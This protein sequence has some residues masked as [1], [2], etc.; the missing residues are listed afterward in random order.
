[1]KTLTKDNFSEALTGNSLVFFHRLKGCGNCDK[2]LPIVEDYKKE[3]V[4]VFDVDCDAEKE[5]VSKYAPNGNWNLPLFVYFEEGKPV[6]VKTGVINIDD[7]TKTLQNVSIMELTE[8]KLEL[9]VQLANKKRET[10]MI[11]KSIASIMEEIDRRYSNTQKAQ[12][13]KTLDLSG[14]PEDPEAPCDGCQ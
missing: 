14:F 7:A 3:G 6:N 12:P 4:K 1:M 13:K 11:E 9:D 5:L 8:T 10:F 2:M